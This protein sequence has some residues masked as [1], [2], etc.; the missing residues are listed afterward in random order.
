MYTSSG[1]N[2]R[3]LEYFGC[4]CFDTSVSKQMSIGSRIANLDPVLLFSSLAQL[5]QLKTHTNRI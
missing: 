4:R 2:D 3:T 5:P 1:L